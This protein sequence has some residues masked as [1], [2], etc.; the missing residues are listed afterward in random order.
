[1]LM[2][3][4]LKNALS[5]SV[6]C[7]NSSFSTEFC[8]AYPHAFMISLDIAMS[9]LKNIQ[10]QNN[11]LCTDATKPCGLRAGV[12]DFV[13]EKGTLDALMSHADSSIGSASGIRLLKEISR[14]L[15]PEGHAF[16]VSHS[17]TRDPLIAAGDLIIVRV[18]RCYLSDEAIIINT[19]RTTGEAV[20]LV[21]K[22][23][24]DAETMVAFRE[25]KVRIAKK[26]LA[27]VMKKFMKNCSD[28]RERG[29]VRCEGD[30]IRKQDFCWIYLVRKNSQ[31]QSND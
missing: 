19:L 25:V 15:S 26:N 29:G 27:N 9:A 28:E 13:M 11:F 6:G 7:G 8:S 3:K 23:G 14:C 21:K 17:P 22:L 24:N 2:H 1:M 12:F 10:T 20:S 5:L 4:T 18:Y 31:Q 16:I 30:D